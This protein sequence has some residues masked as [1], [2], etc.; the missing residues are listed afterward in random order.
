MPASTPSVRQVKDFYMQV[1]LNRSP[2]PSVPQ[3]GIHQ[4]RPAYPGEGFFEIR[5]SDVISIGILLL[6]QTDGG[7][8]SENLDFAQT[9]L[10]DAP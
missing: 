9:S 1:L 4:G 7:G 8:G 6:N 3:G 2:W 5:T 10:M